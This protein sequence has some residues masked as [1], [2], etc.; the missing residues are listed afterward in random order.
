MA[1]DGFLVLFV[2]IFLGAIAVGVFAF[3]QRE[4]RRKELFALANSLG[5]QYSHEDPVGLL[6]LGFNLFRMGDGRGCESVLSGVWDGI[7]VHEADY[8]YYTERTDSKGNR[9]R[10]Y[11]YFS[12]VVAEVGLMVP[13]VTV[14]RENVFTRLADGLG[15]RDLEFEL[16]DFNRRFQVKAFEPEFAYKLIDARMIRWLLSTGGRFGFEVVGPH[17]L[18]YSR[19]VKPAEI[20]VLLNVMKTFRDHVPRIVWNEYGT[21]EAPPRPEDAAARPTTEGGER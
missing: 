9:S 19:R 10:S 12:I 17:L 4:R 21:G 13:H 15:F 11:V 20:P 2:L 3:I 14:S 8:W 7:P 6:G 1:V 5:M 16:E 18:V